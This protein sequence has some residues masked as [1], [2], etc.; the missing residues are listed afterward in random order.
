MAGPVKGSFPKPDPGDRKLWESLLPDHPDLVIRPMFGN[1]A[2]FVKGNMFSGLFG[3]ALFVRL[4]EDQREDVLS[5]GGEGFEPM[6]G[7]PMKEYVSLPG[8]WRKDSETAAG[9]IERSLAFA[10]G[11]PP[12]KP[13]KRT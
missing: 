6:P 3:E 11:L 4:P 8:T 2:A 1:V 10:K 5:A 13:K 7:R 12:K 9:W